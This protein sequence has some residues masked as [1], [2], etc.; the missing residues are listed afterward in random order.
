MGR[1]DSRGG[2]AKWPEVLRLVVA[3]N[4][5]KILLLVSTDKIVDLVVVVQLRLNSNPDSSNAV[6]GRLDL[7]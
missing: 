7:E 3:Q 2:L 5:I 6:I 1:L 4:P